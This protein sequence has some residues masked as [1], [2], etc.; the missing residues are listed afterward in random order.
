MPEDNSFADHIHD[1]V[2]EDMVIEHSEALKKEIQ[3]A[4]KEKLV[5]ML[6]DGAIKFAEQAKEQMKQENFE[7][8][9]NLLIRSQ[10]I[11]LELLYSLDRKKGDEIADNLAKMYTW[12]YNKWV[13]GNVHHQPEKIE[14]G[15]DIV[16][17]LREAWKEAT[18]KVRE[19]S[20]VG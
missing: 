6:Y 19:A 18:K 7:E 11:V 5:L 14:E 1:T 4:S 9:H 12:I 16:R 17:G 8:A 13:E 3:K 2:G 15:L 20:D 10:N